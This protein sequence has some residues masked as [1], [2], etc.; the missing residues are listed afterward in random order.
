MI[1]DHESPKSKQISDESEESEADPAGNSRGAEIGRRPGRCSAR[2]G[3]GWG[4]SIGSEAE[5][6][7]IQN[8]ES[9][10]TLTQRYAKN[11]ERIAPTLTPFFH[12]PLSITA[13]PEIPEI[14][15]VQFRK[16]QVSSLTTEIKSRNI[17][18]QCFPYTF[19][20]SPIAQ[21]PIKQQIGDGTSH[22]SFPHSFVN[23]CTKFQDSGPEALSLYSGN[24]S[25]T[26]SNAPNQQEWK[27]S[28][29]MEKEDLPEESVP[30]QGK[31]VLLGDVLLNPK[32]PEGLSR[33]T[34]GENNKNTNKD[35][36][37]E[38]DQPPPPEN[39]KCGERPTLMEYER[40]QQDPIVEN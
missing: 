36:P 10:L 12:L 14:Y 16:P 20:H 22:S 13:M 38:V 3:T 7:Q 26:Q 24:V 5:P 37:K 23:T 2:R 19:G 33:K 8:Q 11:R 32:T 9:L 29:N 40:Q 35:V 39:G 4:Y 31:V 30:E 34:A 27:S 25:N 28:I 1:P 21:T 17:C 6:D 18:R 15:M